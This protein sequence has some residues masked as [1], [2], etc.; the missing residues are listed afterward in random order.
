MASGRC[1][2][3]P[4]AHAKFG[5]MRAIVRFPL[6]G[7]LGVALALCACDGEKPA[8][9]AQTAAKSGKA[10]GVGAKAKAEDSSAKADAKPDAKADAKP[11]AKAP[12]EGEAAGPTAP[13]IVDGELMLDPEGIGD[14][15][16]GMKAAEVVALMGEPSKKSGIDEEGATG[17]FV[18]SWDYPSKGLGIGMAAPS[19]KGPWSLSNLT[20]NADCPMPGPWGLKIGS[21]RAEVEK[22]YGK[23][24]DPDFTDADQFV[25]GSVYGG[26][27]YGF[28]DGKVSSIFIGAGAE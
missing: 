1:L 21:T 25:A 24:F 5:S 6:F 12:P 13:V 22:I 14:L 2:T 9:K 16:L 26:V 28:T 8:A 11:D 15:R 3:G 7:V 10:Q 23:A 17:D 18:Q 27:F 20:A 4:R 19:A